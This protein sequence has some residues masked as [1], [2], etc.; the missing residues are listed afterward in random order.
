M[1]HITIIVFVIVFLFV[2]IIAF[3]QN[4][5]ENPIQKESTVNENES[6]DVVKSEDK[7]SFTDLITLGALTINGVLVFL[8]YKT[9]RQNNDQHTSINRPWISLQIDTIDGDDNCEFILKNQGNLVAENMKISCKDRKRSKKLDVI[10]KIFYLLPSQESKF[11]FNVADM[12][13]ESSK[14]ETRAGYDVDAEIAITYSFNKKNKKIVYEVVMSYEF[15]EQYE[16]IQL[17]DFN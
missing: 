8:I 17:L 9:F 1:K 16:S 14:T 4:I 3:A 6:T 13:I 10:H 7:I 15:G 12:V 5:P 2:P 11:Y